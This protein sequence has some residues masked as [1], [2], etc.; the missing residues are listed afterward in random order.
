[1]AKDRASTIIDVLYGE[2]QEL[3]KIVDQL[4][5]PSM[6]TWT[7]NQFRRTLV[8]AIGSYFEHEITEIVTGFVERETQRSE[9]VVA[10][11]K[12]KGISR[13][14]HTYFTWKDNNANQFFGL[15]GPACKAKHVSDV[16]A[17]EQLREAAQA[18][19][20]L[21]R[22]RNTLAHENYVTFLVDKTAAEVYERFR[23]AV[24]FVDYVDEL[25]DAYSARS[26]ATP[27]AA[28]MTEADADAV[29]GQ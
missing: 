25:L 6:Y 2:F 20:E 28:A 27:E 11:A 26:Q 3:L 16:N 29:A 5:E 10:F 12:A 22:L 18:F 24:R 17:S 14:Y 21:G 13:Q 1:M 15:F 7:D 4:I 19:L 23:S 8:M 9:W